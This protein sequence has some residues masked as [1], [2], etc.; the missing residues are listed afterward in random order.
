MADYLQ[1]IVLM[2]VIIAAFYFLMR[3][4]DIYDD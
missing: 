1:V 4:D 2:G 3:E